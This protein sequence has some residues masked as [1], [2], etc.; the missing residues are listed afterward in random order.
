M[1]CSLSAYEDED[2]ILRLSANHMP[3]CV[4]DLS[5][6][7]PLCVPDPPDSTKIPCYDKPQ[8]AF[9]CIYCHLIDKTVNNFSED[10]NGVIFNRCM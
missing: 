10:N 5:F 1:T 7:V 6:T 2:D 9:L 3:Y 4:D 8:V